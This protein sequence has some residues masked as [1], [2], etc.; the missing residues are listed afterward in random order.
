VVIGRVPVGDRQLAMLG[1]L[2]EGEVEGGV[3]CGYPELRVRDDIVDPLPP[4]V[5]LAPVAETVEELLRSPHVSSLPVP[6]ERTRT[7]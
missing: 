5:D 7:L 6:L 2:G 4:V 3:P 1:L